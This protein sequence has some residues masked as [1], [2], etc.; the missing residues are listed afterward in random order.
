M[1]WNEDILASQSYKM[2]L[3]ENIQNNL[4]LLQ[5]TKS[6]STKMKLTLYNLQI[7]MPFFNNIFYCFH[8]I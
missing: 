1:A 7:C 8:I 5:P 4:Q 3:I 6:L 2:L